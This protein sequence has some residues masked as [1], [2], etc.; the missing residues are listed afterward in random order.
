[1][2]ADHLAELQAKLDATPAMRKQLNGALLGDALAE[3]TADQ[4]HDDVQVADSEGRPRKQ[5]DVLVDIA[6]QH[7][8][9]HSPDRLAYARVERA[10]YQVDSTS[11]REMLAKTYFDLAGKGCN[12]NALA[13]AVV[14]I[15]SIAKFAGT[16]RQVWLRTGETQGAMYI[17]MG[18][19]DQQKIEATATGWRFTNDGPMF[20]RTSAMGELPEPRSPD[21]SRLW[22]Y[23]NVTPDH[24]VLVAAFMLAALRPRGPYPI[25]FLAGEQGTG[26][27]TLARVIRRLVDPSA[28]ALRAPPKDVRDLLV[29]ALNG[30]VLALDNLSFLG[31]Q[32]SDA[33]C[34]LATGGAISE[35]QLY[36]NAEEVLIEVQRPVIVNGIEDLAVRPDLAERGLHV[37]LELIQHRR[38]EAE[39]WRAFDADAP[40]IF[41][42]LLEATSRAIRDHATIQLG[43]LPRMAD[44]AMW[45]AAGMLD[46]GFTPAEFIDAYRINQDM[47]MG[48]GV[49]SSPVGRAIV[50]FI[51]RRKIW[52]GTAA[53]LLAN[54]GHD[55][56]DGHDGLLRSPAW[57]KSPRGLAGAVRRLAP[58]L[59]LAGIEVDTDRTAA[60]RTI[61][62]CYRGERPSSPSQPSLPQLRN[63]GHDANDGHS[64]QQHDA[65]AVL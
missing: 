1:M 22:N 58:A 28:S 41:C 10:V 7:D 35:R 5:A 14:T 46:L 33:L 62:L 8:L 60:S 43:K 65:G 17:D 12:K 16:M 25:L 30:W 38:S 27:S 13:D 57:P 59:R 50:A 21:F 45:A 56:N 23:I 37:E 53:E 42:A 47:G 44:F 29:G 32:L 6:R 19:S 18:R 64:G 52:T 54:I 24:R 4:H 51:T 34:R 39:F 26:K 11:Y 49:D 31:P 63:D 36:T 2:S 9:F 20:R 55:A 15:S 40:H 61:R 3:A 48:A